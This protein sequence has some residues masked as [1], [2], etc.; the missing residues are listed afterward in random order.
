MTTKVTVT[1]EGPDK[2]IVYE[3]DVLSGGPGFDGTHE[4]CVNEHVL[5]KDETKT[6]YVYKSRILSIEEIEVE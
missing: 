1:N 4:S 5:D 2:V 3:T 6:F